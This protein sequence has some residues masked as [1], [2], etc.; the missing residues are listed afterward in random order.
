LVPAD[1]GVSEEALVITI[2]SLLEA[3]RA[4]PGHHAV[5]VMSVEQYDDWI[6]PG[7]QRA[8]EDAKRARARAR[9]DCA[10][11]E[12]VLPSITRKS[13]IKA[14]F[15]PAW[16]ETQLGRR[17]GTVGGPAQSAHQ[18]LNH[19]QGNNTEIAGLYLVGDSTYPGEGVVAAAVSAVT[20]VDQIAAQKGPKRSPWASFFSRLSYQKTRTSKSGEYAAITDDRPA[21]KPDAQTVARMAGLGDGTH[22]ETATETATETETERKRE[23]T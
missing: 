10:L 11:A 8:R 23:S 13:E 17:Y 20:C 19:R 22:S 9:Q 21:V 7:F 14:T 4:P 5:T 16:M 6:P 1:S 18:S 3:H 2:P 15:S 12:T